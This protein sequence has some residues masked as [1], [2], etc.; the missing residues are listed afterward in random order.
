M[1][2]KR[3]EKKLD[4]SCKDHHLPLDAQFVPN[5]GF[6]WVLPSVLEYYLNDRVL[7]ERFLP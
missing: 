4:L 7:N 6:L 2:E 1:V 5:I 3:P